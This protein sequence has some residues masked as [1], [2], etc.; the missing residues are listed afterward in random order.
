VQPIIDPDSWAMG[1]RSAANPHPADA[2]RLADT[3]TESDKYDSFWEGRRNAQEALRT[4]GWAT[5]GMLAGRYGVAEDSA[6]T[7]LTSLGAA[8]NMRNTFWA[9]W[10]CETALASPEWI[11]EMKRMLL[12]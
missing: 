6:S 2:G 4:Q 1:C 5:L 9:G 11:A 12:R 10:K 3:L 8:A 7:I